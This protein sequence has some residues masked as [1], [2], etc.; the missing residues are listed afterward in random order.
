MG[1]IPEQHSS[2]K[3][4]PKTCACGQVFSP[5]PSNYAKA[6]RCPECAAQ[7]RK[8]GSKLATA[9]RD[10]ERALA[11]LAATHVI[12]IDGEGV[13][14]ITYLGDG[15]PLTDPDPAMFWENHV[16]SFM[17][18]YDET[19][20]QHDHLFPLPGDRRLRTN[21][22]LWWLWRNT[23]KPE[24][25]GRCEPWFYSAKYDWTGVFR[26]I[27]I[28]DV[29][30][31]HPITAGTLWQVLH[32]EQ[33]PDGADRDPF[34]PVWWNGWGI[35]YI[36][37]VV[38]LQRRRWDKETH[39]WRPAGRR[40]FADAFRCFGAG[41]FVS[42]LEAWEVADEA[43][44]AE[45]QR[46]KDLRGHFSVID[47]EVIAYCDREVQLL[48]EGVKKIKLVFGS[49]E[50]GIRPRLW[51]SA[52]SAAK[53]LMSKNH[54]EDYRGPDRFAGAPEHL[55]LAL[56]RAYQGG[57]FEN[58]ETGLFDELH[59][60]DFKSA[61]PATI[62]D[63]PC[64]AHGHW[65]ERYV[66]GA[67]N[68]GHVEWEPAHNREL[69]WA[70]FAWRYPEGRIYR[71]HTGEGWYHEVEIQAAQELPDYTITE[72][73]WVAFV[74]GCDHKPF[75]F[76]Q[77]TY[78]LRVSWGGDGRGLALKVTLNSIYG[79]TADTLSVDSRY[80]NII[81]AGIIT[82]GTR[83]KILR[84][85]AEHGEQIVSVATDGILSTSPVLGQRTK[86]LGELN[87]EGPIRGVLL[88]QP[89]SYL[90]VEGPDPKKTI[91]NRGHALK[92]MR[93]IEAEL[94]AQWR[95]HGWSAQVT[96]KRTRFIPAKLALSR[97]DPLLVYGQWIT[98]D[99]TLKFTP[100]NREPV[101]E[102]GQHKR[103]I[104]SARHITHMLR[105][106]PEQWDMLCS[107]PYDRLV[108]IAYNQEYIDRRE[109]DHAQP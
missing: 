15:D 98:E 93:A 81:W 12:G 78:D 53:A 47:E 34:E 83:A 2:N 6:L 103:S 18:A 44:R 99:V 82:A 68:I 41:S 26:D 29:T 50:I 22:I 96:Y 57:W 89:G 54:V 75:A 95:L 9:R 76:V 65:E 33:F 58:A 24:D 25:G 62:R 37:G 4:P 52:G 46:M 105:R 13:N 94:R 64:M 106:Y 70:P 32:P 80:A 45:I 108:S 48:A 100:S 56:L 59:S 23:R 10:E 51:F 42:W 49:S 21:E 17:S 72:L 63:L 79:V 85:I 1:T 43:E 101:D 92:D 7:R 104:P 16:Y 40:H 67:L 19:T 61:Y 102:P 5:R 73:E 30:S 88:V 20:G 84:L 14:E 39:D 107:A 35:T 38:G 71:P 87:Y 8:T 74:P 97:K 69:R 77:D 66:P 11:A 55:R 109:L 31:G 60:E 86:T 28:E 90:A 36:Q 27:I 91:R 3:Y